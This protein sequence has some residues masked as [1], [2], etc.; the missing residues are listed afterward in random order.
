MRRSLG[1]ASTRVRYPSHAHPGATWQ[2]FSR[3][4][5]VLPQD[6]PLWQILQHVCAVAVERPVRPADG[7]DDECDDA[8][9]SARAEVVS[10]PKSIRTR[11]VRSMGFIHGRVRH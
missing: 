8:G 2:I 4:I 10:D 7:A 11:K 1:D 6:L 3:E 5:Q 9:E